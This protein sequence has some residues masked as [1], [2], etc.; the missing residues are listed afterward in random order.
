[1]LPV[2]TVIG[3]T[4]AAGFSGAVIMEQVFSIPGLGSYTVAA[5]TNRDYPA[6]QAVVL[7]I[8][9]AFCLTNLVIDISYVVI[10]PRVR[11][12]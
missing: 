10:D 1:M 7:L 8:G 11:L 3:L 9:A 6:I 4:T 12:S 5:L 2:I